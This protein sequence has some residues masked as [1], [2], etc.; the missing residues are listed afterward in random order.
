MVNI[1]QI[2]TGFG[3]QWDGHSIFVFLRRIKELTSTKGAKNFPRWIIPFMFV[4]TL[5]CG[6]ISIQLHVLLNAFTSHVSLRQSLCFFVYLRQILFLFVIGMI[7]M[8]F[9]QSHQC[10]SM[11]LILVDPLISYS[12]ITIKVGGAHSIDKVKGGAGAMSFTTRLGSRQQTG[13]GS[14]V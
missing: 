2:K 9:I 13:L 7:L 1:Y 11:S 10:I 8:S 6:I 4:V 3:Y 12:L 14:F 5:Y